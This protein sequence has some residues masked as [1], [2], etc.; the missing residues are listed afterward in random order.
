M[1]RPAGPAPPR[2]GPLTA[3]MRAPLCV[4]PLAT[5][6]VVPLPR[7]VSDFC[8]LTIMCEEPN[9][10]AAPLFSA[11]MLTLGRALDEAMD[12]ESQGLNARTWNAWAPCGVGRAQVRW[13]W[14]VS[15]IDDRRA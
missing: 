11:D 6:T 3:W 13:T 12:T 14:V 2:A 4:E 9:A 15:K 8:L 5:A 10:S 7:F 1:G